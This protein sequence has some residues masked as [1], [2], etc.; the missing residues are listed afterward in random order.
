MSINSKHVKT[1]NASDSDRELLSRIADRDEAALIQVIELYAGQV[2]SICLRICSDELEADGLVSVV[3]WELWN[4]FAKYD[5]C[6]GSLR[7]YLL[8][9]ARSRA[10]DWQR[11]ATARNRNLQQFFLASHRHSTAGEQTMNEGTNA[12]ESREHSEELRRA[13]ELLPAHQKS[14]LELA[15]FDGLTHREV[16]ERQ[17]LPL[18]TIK[19]NIRR[20]LLQLRRILIEVTNQER[21]LA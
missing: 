1:L 14:A 5:H 17:S 3:F 8:T 20:G 21:E 18:G 16:A 6:R 12:Q 15:F 19:T 13:I 11:A 4:G 7:S 2:K 10:I 9:L